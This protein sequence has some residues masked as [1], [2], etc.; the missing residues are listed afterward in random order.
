MTDGLMRQQMQDMTQGISVSIHNLGSLNCLLLLFLK[1]SVGD[2][3]I[4]SS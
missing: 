1:F 3:H 4:L 2:K